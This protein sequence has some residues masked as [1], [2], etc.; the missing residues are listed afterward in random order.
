MPEAY[1]LQSLQ[2]G[3]GTVEGALQ[4]SFVSKQPFEFWT[5]RDPASQLFEARSL[6]LD[7]SMFFANLLQAFYFDINFPQHFISTGFC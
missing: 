6:H 2:L 3:H 4:T 7:G 1:A 5:F